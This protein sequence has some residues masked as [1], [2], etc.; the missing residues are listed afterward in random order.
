[1]KEAAPWIVAGLLAVALLLLAA[2]QDRAIEQAPDFSLEALDGEAV[3]LS[4]LRGRVVILDFWASWCKPCTKTLPELHAVAERHADQ[5]VVFLAVSLDRSES[6]AREYAQDHGLSAS[7]V[8]YGSLEDARRVKD[9]FEVVGI[10]RTFVVD[11]EGWV[12]YSG[13]PVGVT[14]ELLAP[15]L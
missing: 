14:D 11:R 2:P 7:S 12:R 3:T 9:L 4:A 15:W 5:G 1:M 8:L 10:P 13:S 6:A